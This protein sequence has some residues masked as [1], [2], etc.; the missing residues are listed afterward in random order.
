MRT[1]A[2]PVA[3]SR[4]DPLVARLTGWLGGPTGLYARIRWDPRAP[5]V[6]VAVVTTL[7]MLAGLWQKGACY[8]IAWDRSAGNKGDFL[9]NHT[10]YSDIAI[11]YR[12]RGFAQHRVPYL[13]TGSYPVLEYPVLTGFVMQATALIARAIGPGPVVGTSVTFFD[14]NAVLLFG[15]ALVVGWSIVALSGSRRWDAL[16]FAG[17]PVLALSGTI[18][19]DLVAVALTG[20]AMVLWMRRHPWMAGVLLGLGAATKL[21][22]M[23]VAGPLLVLALRSGRLLGWVKLMVA[24]AV[25]WSAVNLPVI[26]LAP[27]QWRYFF[28]F[29]DDREAD[30][31]SLWFVLHLAGRDLTDLNRTSLLLFGIGCGFVALLTL[32]A[33]RRPRVPQVVFLVIAI[34]LLVNKV[35]SPQYVLWMLPLAIL[36]HPRVRDVLI[37]QSVEVLY[38]LMV[39]MYLGGLYAQH[40]VGRWY[41]LAV[42]VRLL[43]TLWFCGLV[44]RDVLG[45]SHDPV[46]ADPAVDDPA[47][48]EFDHA[49]DAG[50]RRRLSDAFAHG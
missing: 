1:G 3:P 7:T 5:L 28:D 46:R 20:V 36:A 22:P 27:E 11:L 19:W 21:Y 45:P 16:L 2:P 10:C 50:W 44:V 4:D 29:N 23:F 38:W 8:E 40:P 35:Y 12:E 13:Q 34:F 6:A 14:V 26:V 24:G 43:A 17:A 18:N 49:P 31:G 47:G 30:F 37:W 41:W 42:V 33:P 9:F 48:G 25:A 39:W 32:S 15:M